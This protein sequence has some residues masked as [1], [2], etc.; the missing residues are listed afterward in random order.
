MA[1]A[2]HAFATGCGAQVPCGISV[3][4]ATQPVNLFVRLTPEQRQLPEPRLRDV[5]PWLRQRDGGTGILQAL[6][7]QLWRRTPTF[8]DIRVAPDMD[9]LRQMPGCYPSRVCSPKFVQDIDQLTCRELAVALWGIAHGIDQELHSLMERARA[10]LQD[11]V[12]GPYT[13]DAAY[14]PVE[15]WAERTGVLW[16]CWGW[17]NFAGCLRPQNRERLDSIGTC[18]TSPLVA[19]RGPYEMAPTEAPASVE[20]TLRSGGGQL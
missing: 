19:I 6:V 12:P 3:P 14:T 2:A 20:A 17:V 11:A 16:E 9:Y 8:E 18:D 13:E 4:Y 15:V 7:Q 5:L 10:V 1:Q